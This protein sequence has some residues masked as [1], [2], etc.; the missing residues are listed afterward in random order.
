MSRSIISRRPAVLLAAVNL[1]GFNDLGVLRA[2]YGNKPPSAAEE[3]DLDDE[4]AGDELTDSSGTGNSAGNSGGGADSTTSTGGSGGKSVHVVPLTKK[5]FDDTTSKTPFVLV[6]FFAPWCGHCKAMA[7]EYDDLAKEVKTLMGTVSGGNGAAWRNEL[8]SAALEKAKNNGVA[9]VLVGEV[10]ATVDAELAEA[11]G[12][13]GYPT[14][15]LFFNGKKRSEYLGTRTM[16]AML[17]WLKTSVGPLLNVVKTEKEI[18]TVLESRKPVGA[19]AVFKGDSKVEEI[20]REAAELNAIRTKVLYFPSTT[21]EITMYKG[22]TEREVVT[23]LS[24]IPTGTGI[25]D[26]FSKFRQPLFGQISEDNFELYMTSAKSG[27][28]WVCFDPADVQAALTQFSQTIVLAA[29]LTIKAGRDKFPFVWLDISEFEEHARQ[30]LGCTKYPTIVLQKG[31]ILTESDQEVEKFSKSFAEDPSLLTAAAVLEFLDDVA[32]GK[33]Q[34]E[35]KDE[36]DEMD[37]D[38]NMGGEEDEDELEDEEE[39]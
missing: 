35:V 36:L 25:S 4:L 13:T 9:P 7:G 19:V 6:K 16:S 3:D 14:V 37:E 17:D 15:A 8:D 12:V 39:L 24:T 2:V 18:E 22:T 33:M 20:A 29:E 23:D 11:Y 5:N 30:E 27:L 28:L 1:F 34:S 26:W 32:A 21:T 31:D 10:D 38:E